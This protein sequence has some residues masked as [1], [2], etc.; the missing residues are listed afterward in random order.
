MTKHHSPT[1][2]RRIGRAAAKVALAAL[3]PLTLALPAVTTPVQ[4]VTPLIKKG[5]IVVGSSGNIWEGSTIDKIDPVTGARTRVSTGGR[6][7]WPTAV[8]SDLDGN[9]YAGGRDMGIVRIDH[10]TGEQKVLVYAGGVDPADMVLGPDGNLIIASS[11][12]AGGQIAVLNP[13]DGAR[14]TIDSD[15]PMG[16]DL[17]AVAVEFDGSIL[18]LDRGW[19]QLVRIDVGT[20]DG[21]VLTEFPDSAS[22]N[23]LAVAQDGNILVRL[24]AADGAE[25]LIKVDRKTGA[26]KVL[27]SSTSMYSS[28]GMARQADGSIL[29]AQMDY[30]TDTSAIVKFAANGGSRT[31]LAKFADGE[32]LDVTVAGVAQI[33]PE[34]LPMA[35]G[36]VYTMERPSAELHVTTANG[37][38]ANDVD[39]AYGMTLKGEVVTQ[40]SHGSV[41]ML[42]T[43]TGEFFYWPAAGF[44]G[45]DTFTYRVRTPDGRISAPATVT[46]NVLPDQRPTAK[47]DFFNAAAGRTLFVG[48]GGVLFNDSD[49]QGDP[50][51]ATQL[52]QPAH[53]SATI[54][55][56]GDLT[57]TAN[58]GFVGEDTL[59]YSASDGKGH[60]SLTATVHISVPPA[61][62][63]NVPTV[64]PTKGGT[65]SAD[66]LSGT[67]NLGVFDFET[68]AGSLTLSAT[69]SNTALVPNAN[70]TFGGTGS[71]RT[72]TVK[73][74]AGKSGTAVI[75][76]KV[77]DATGA[78]GNFTIV[79][80]VG[81]DNSETITGTENADLLLGLG[82]N[83]TLLGNGG[84]DLISGGTG[85]DTMTGGAG[86]DSFRGHSGT[87]R[88]KDF[89][90]AAG[91]TMTEASA[92]QP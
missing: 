55:L 15:E 57:Y 16:S 14:G 70:L 81:T 56:N 85:N 36:D 26:Q 51:Q 46:V 63:N 20:N 84:F 39:P 37:P 90:P 83:D 76:V 60:A 40:P 48:A 5:D 17:A 89:N 75:T 78:N 21:H 45:T 87:N 38:L 72:L 69:S 13:N 43:G 31:T 27:A 10:V 67:F 25:Q 11:T 62:A 49:P 41:G 66:G 2:R 47:D 54:A 35:R 22:A 79:A 52:S 34:P 29:D 77:T 65:L 91:E 24:A 19:D 33:L 32:T 58:P 68:P 30:D 8:V 82:G 12:F 3:A 28:Y 44:T 61:T 6:L 50:L 1:P 88:V 74:V 53:G 7:N 18:V 71:S 42:S 86:T 64:G 80:T 23:S 92:I 4:A 73:A 59:T 9:I